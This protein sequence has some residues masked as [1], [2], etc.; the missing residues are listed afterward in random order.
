MNIALALFLSLPP[1][2]PSIVEEVDTKPSFKPRIAAL[3]HG[4]L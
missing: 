2:T 1:P 4:A 3:N